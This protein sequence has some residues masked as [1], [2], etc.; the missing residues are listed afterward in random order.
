MSALA[1][2]LDSWGIYV[3]GSDLADNDETEILKEKGITVFKGHNKVNLKNADVVVYSSAIHDDNDELVFAKEHNL[4]IFRRAELL[5]YVASLYRNVIA[6]AGSHGKTTATAMIAEIFLKAGLDPTFHIGGT[7]CSTNSNYRLG[8][9]KVFITE[10]CEYKDNFLYIKPDVAIVLNVDGDH[11]DYFGSIEGVKSSFK[12]FVDGKR[13]GGISIICADDKN[14]KNLINED[15]TTTFGLC[16]QAEIGA[17]NIHQYKNGFYAFNPTFMGYCFDEIKLNIVGKHNILNALAA[18]LVGIVFDI[19]FSYI[20][21]AL[22]GFS[23]TRRRCQVV[24]NANGATVFHDYAHHPVQIKKMVE[25]AKE[26][27]NGKGR[28]ITVFEPHT[29]S[30]TKFLLGEFAEA[31][32]GCDISIFCPAYSAREDLSE[33]YEADVLAEETKKYVKDVSF[34]KTFDEV[35]KNIFSVARADDIVLILGAGTI[36]HLAKMF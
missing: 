1:Q 6:I 4:L 26:F 18:M 9:D 16:D 19:D 29:Y 3:Q 11:L 34:V 5:G 14:S 31:F 32:R 35:F 10:A 25:V 27:T 28:I 12:K 23:G 20:K 24:G 22:E 13:C 17:T 15:D 30:R 36:E 33:G 21:E 2:M 8:S 7:L